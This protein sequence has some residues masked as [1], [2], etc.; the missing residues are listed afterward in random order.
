MVG[1]VKVSQSLDQW[2]SGTVQREFG[3]SATA[4]QS[5]GRAGT[6]GPQGSPCA[7]GDQGPAGPAGTAG[8]NATGIIAIIIAIVAVV[9]SVGIP[10]VMPRR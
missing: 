6:L 9:V 8:S 4:T 2:T 3:L 5:V 1:G 7:A 10:F